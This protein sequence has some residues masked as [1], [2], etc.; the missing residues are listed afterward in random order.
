MFRAK[1]EEKRNQAAI[2][3]ENERAKW[4]KRFD[5]RHQQPKVYAEQDLV[6][7]ENEPASTGDSR[8]LEP[9]FRG[10]Y[11]VRKVLGNDRYLLEDI[12]GYQ[13]SNKS[14]ILY[15]PPIK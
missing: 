5:Q 2:N 3:I 15:T 11:I 1:L 13:V 9:K 7:I 8:K 10:P 14:L 12:P 4:K 6:V